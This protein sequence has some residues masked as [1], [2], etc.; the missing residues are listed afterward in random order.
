[1]LE[2][3]RKKSTSG[4]INVIRAVKK[5]SGRY[6]TSLQSTQHFPLL[7][8]LCIHGVGLAYHHC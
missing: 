8:E 3:L 2:N 7:K 6:M 5:T 1:M 4:Q